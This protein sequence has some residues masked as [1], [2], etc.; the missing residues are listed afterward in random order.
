VRAQSSGLRTEMIDHQV[1]GLPV[2]FRWLFRVAAGCLLVAD[3]AIGG[4][5]P[6]R[7]P[8]MS[9]EAMF[10][11]LSCYTRAG[12]QSRPERND[13][14]RRP[15]RSLVGEGSWPLTCDIHQFLATAFI[16]AVSRCDVAAV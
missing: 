5:A 7:V 3:F 10:L 2:R 14:P 13:A 8:L 12:G 9:D 1:F 16:C 11:A 4:V 15:R 6:V